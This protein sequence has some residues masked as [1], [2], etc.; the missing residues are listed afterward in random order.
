MLVNQISDWWVDMW[1][2]VLTWQTLAGKGVDTI[3]TRS[4][5]LTRCRQALV[6]FIFA[7]L[8]EIARL[9]VTNKPACEANKETDRH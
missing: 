5:V 4:A 8:T 7:S 6:N 9:A 2:K 3:F 1:W